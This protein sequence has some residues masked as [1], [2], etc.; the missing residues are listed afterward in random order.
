MVAERFQR[1]QQIRGVETGFVRR[2]CELHHGLRSRGAFVWLAC[3]HIGDQGQGIAC[4]RELNGPLIG[5]LEEPGNRFQR[6]DLRTMARA[7]G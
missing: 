4:H 7:G 3:L 6:G 5:R 2:L 1:F